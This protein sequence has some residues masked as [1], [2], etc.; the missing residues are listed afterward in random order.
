MKD[1]KPKTYQCRV[2]NELSRIFVDVYKHSKSMRHQIESGIK[3]INT[4][5]TT[6]PMSTPKY[7]AKIAQLLDTEPEFGPADT[8]L[9]IV[10]Q[11]ASSVPGEASSQIYDDDVVEHILDTAVTEAQIFLKISASWYWRIVDSDAV[12]D[13]VQHLE[14]SQLYAFIT[15]HS[16]DHRL[17]NVKKL[18]HFIRV[19]LLEIEKL[20]VVGWNYE[21]P[22]LSRDTKN[23]LYAIM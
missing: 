16:A 13:L 11:F 12:D 21:A 4:I 9:Q 22:N 20:E 17:S 15:R 7:K 10:L 18:D 8:N 6:Y 1:S 23:R 3:C 14:S 19:F 5:K 2:F